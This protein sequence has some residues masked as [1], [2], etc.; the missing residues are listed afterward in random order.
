MHM[1]L[2]LGEGLISGENADKCRC[3]A[4][5]FLLEM[6]EGPHGHYSLKKGFLRVK[7]ALNRFLV[8]TT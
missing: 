4:K 5:A 2:T 7:Y 3:C 8:G 6:F 1:K